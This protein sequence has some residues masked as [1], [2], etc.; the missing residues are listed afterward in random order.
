[1]R[2]ARVFPEPVRAAPRTSFPARRTGMDLAWTGVIVVKPISERAREVGSERSKVENGSRAD[3]VDDWG[4]V[5][6]GFEG[7]A[8]TTFSLLFLLGDIVVKR[9]RPADAEHRHELF[10]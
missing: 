5:E 7:P 10:H 1:M 6:G 2:K 3:S 9:E 4:E 8:S